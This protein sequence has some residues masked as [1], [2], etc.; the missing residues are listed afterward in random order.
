M[1]PETRDSPAATSGRAVS[2]W[3]LVL[4]VLAVAIGSAWVGAWWARQSLRT[5]LT[6]RPPVVLFDMAG[7]VRDV[8]PERLAA[9]VARET[10]RARRLAE[11]GVLVLDA[12]AVIAAPPDLYLVPSR[13]AEPAGDA[14]R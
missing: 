3:V 1:A 2:P 4:S 10:A 9:V 7:A 5:E 13:T 11:G 6:L 12:Q 14:P 8:S